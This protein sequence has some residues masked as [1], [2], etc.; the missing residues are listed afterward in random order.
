M[1]VFECLR[2]YRAA[3]R[4]G[5]PFEEREQSFRPLVAVTRVLRVDVDVAERVAALWAPAAF[6]FSTGRAKHAPRANPADRHLLA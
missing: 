6:A 5:K 4:A 1:T 2:G 3:I